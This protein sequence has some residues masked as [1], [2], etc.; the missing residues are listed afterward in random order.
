MDTFR[1]EW[2]RQQTHSSCLLIFPTR[3][4]A[5]TNCWPEQTSWHVCDSLIAS[6][7]W[8]DDYETCWDDHQCNRLRSVIWHLITI[9]L[10]DLSIESKQSSILS[11]DVQQFAV[12]FL[13]RSD[14]VFFHVSKNNQRWLIREA[15]PDDAVTL[16]AASGWLCGTFGQSPKTFLIWSCSRPPQVIYESKFWLQSH[17]L[18]RR[19][20]IVSKAW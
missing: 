19:R 6:L 12:H 2:G 13:T 16:S 17:R 14:N 3:R 15:R 5:T 10:I 8:F 4:K 9:A 1:V 20:K 11:T 7:S 18:I